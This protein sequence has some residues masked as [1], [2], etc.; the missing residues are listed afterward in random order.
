MSKKTNQLRGYSR[1]A[2]VLQ[3]FQNLKK[4]IARN[5][6]L[7]AGKNIEKPPHNNDPRK[8]RDLLVQEGKDDE[9]A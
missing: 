6:A 3:E 8:V 9:T 4:W 1:L 7:D 5:S 2:S